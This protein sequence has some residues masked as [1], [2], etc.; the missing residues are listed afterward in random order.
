MLKLNYKK[1][2][3]EI[4]FNGIKVL[5]TRHT[6]NFIKDFLYCD[7]DNA[8]LII[9]NKNIKDKNIIYINDL[10]RYD[11]F[12]SLNKN[13]T[14]YKKIIEKI[15]DNTLVNQ[16]LINEIVS[17]LNNEFGRDIIEHQ[18]DINKIISGSFELIS[19]GCMEE[20]DIF[21]I[22]NK[23]DFDERKLIIFDN[24]SYVKYSNV[25]QLL[26]NFDILIVCSDIR[27]VIDNISQL[28]LCCFVNNG[29]FDVINVE[30][31]LSYLE[32]KT[33]QKI[34]H[35]DINN[36]LNLK[37]DQKSSIINFYLKSI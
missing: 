11:D 24:V 6:T 31:L 34:D 25:K 27:G 21:N 10:T 3:Y 14:V 15:A 29:I 35:E 22:L 30:K 4:E 13:G 9:N 28:E 20:K 16:Q 33:S 37:N 18:Y 23:L 7:D 1:N 8:R 5:E 36:F 19:L 2:W 12:L 17:A 26:N 32:M